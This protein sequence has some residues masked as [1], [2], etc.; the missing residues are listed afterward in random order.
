MA[1]IPAEEADSRRHLA[2]TLE[3]L[4]LDELKHHVAEGLRKILAHR[5]GAEC[6]HLLLELGGDGVRRA[7]AAHEK[8]SAGAHEEREVE[9][10]LRRGLS[11]AAEAVERQFTRIRSGLGDTR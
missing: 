2:A 8:E 9:L 5:P 7:L 1:K 11:P 10:P 4:H 3:A 6:L